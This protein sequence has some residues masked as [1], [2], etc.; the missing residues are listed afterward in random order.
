MAN[1]SEKLLSTADSLLNVSDGRVSQYSQ[2]SL[3]TPEILG[4]FEIDAAPEHDPREQPEMDTG[5]TSDEDE[6]EK[7][8]MSDESNDLQRPPGD[9][10]VYRYYLKAAGVR[11]LFV[12]TL[13][14]ILNVFSGAFSSTCP[15]PITTNCLQLWLIHSSGI[16]LKWWSDVGGQQIELYSSIYFLLAIGYVSGIG[17]YAWYVRSADHSQADR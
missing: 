17:G 2:E 5:S 3:N 9:I 7:I 13:F 1:I 14:V 16:W 12:F 8:A 6:T 10:A 11:R 15:S 4:A